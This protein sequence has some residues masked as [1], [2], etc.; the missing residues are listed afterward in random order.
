MIKWI[1]TSKTKITK[2]Q[3]GNVLFLILIAVAL[4]AALS[5]AVTQ[6]TRS[7]GGNT[8]NE[9][10]GINA[11][12]LTQY[13][14]SVR[15]SIVRM[16]IGGVNAT[17]LEFNPS[18]DFGGLTSTTVG[19]FHPEGGGA[20]HVTAPSTL[21]E[22]GVPGTW[23]F[24]PE[25]EIVNVGVSTPSD[26]GGNDFIAFLPGITRTLCD[27]INDDLGVGGDTVL[28]TNVTARIEVIMED[29]YSLPNDELILGDVDSPGL[30]GQ[31]YGCFENPTTPDP[32]YVYY[33]L[34]LEQ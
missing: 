27:R 16:I 20:T 7:G 21:M 33:H 8:S 23:Y 13:P 24:N 5:Y 34:L 22:G 3:D 28:A 26:F 15:T 18:S 29:G 1:T 25:F 19:V 32:T 14:A 31:A 11:A 30:A 2:H 9:T 10:A 12:Q 17:D 6:S 4:F